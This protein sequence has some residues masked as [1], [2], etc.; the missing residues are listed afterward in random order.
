M[1][2][3]SHCLLSDCKS[4]R[5]PFGPIFGFVWIFFFFFEAFSLLICIHSF[6]SF[7][8]LFPFSLTFQAE[9]FW[10]GQ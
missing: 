2:L 7:S 6:L 4:Y 10:R 8:H 5:S 3:E 1:W 9:W